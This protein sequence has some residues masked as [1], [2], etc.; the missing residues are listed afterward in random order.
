[1]GCEQCL[2]YVSMFRECKS[3]EALPDISKWN[4]KEVENMA[5]MFQNCEKLKE[6]PPIAKWDVT[7]LYNCKNIF[8]VYAGFN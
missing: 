8:D 3:L 4:T 5:Q 1:M 6:K 2:Y 7:M